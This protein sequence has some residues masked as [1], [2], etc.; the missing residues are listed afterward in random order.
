MKTASLGTNGTF[1]FNHIRSDRT[2]NYLL[3]L[4]ICPDKIVFNAWRRCVTSESGVGSDG[5]GQSTTHKLTKRLVEMRPIEELIG[6]I[7]VEVQLQ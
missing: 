5:D 7:M 4:D 6:W 1:Q 2:Y 3:C